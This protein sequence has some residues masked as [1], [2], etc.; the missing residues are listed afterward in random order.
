MARPQHPLPHT[1]ST[2]V[3]GLPGF[4]GGTALQLQQPEL[5]PQTHY[6]VLLFG[7]LLGLALV[8]R[9]LPAGW[10]RGLIAAACM[11]AAGFALTGVRASVF[12][13]AALQPHLEGRDLQ[14]TGVVA[15]M[16]QV[17]E[18]GSRF[19]LQVEQ[20]T[21]EGRAV[22]LPALIYLSWYSGAIGAAGNGEAAQL[23]YQP[24]E[25]RAGERWSMLVRLKAP[26][27]NLNPHGFDYELWLWEHG[28]QATGYVRAGSADPPPR[29]WAQTWRHPVEALRQD[30]RERILQRV[31][32]RSV[33]GVLAA[34]VVGDQNAIERADWDSFRAA[35]VAHLMSIS[36][37]HV[38]MFA[39]FAA[40]LVGAL[41][42]R[43]GV[44]C[45]WCSASHASIVGGLLLAT[46]YALFSGWGAPSQRTIWML[47]T[48]GLLRLSARRWPWPV[49]WLLA[50]VA[51][52]LLDPW[53]LNQPGFWLSFVAVAVLFAS[54]S[55]APTISGWSTRLRAMLREQW[56]VTAALTPLS[57][58]LFGQASV[59]GLAANLLAIPWVT[60]LVT[61]LALAGVV[62]APLWDLAAG[63]V[64]LLV[65]TLQLLLQLPLSSVSV[66]QAPLWAG[67]AGVA[68]GV[69]LVLRLPW[70]VRAAGLPLLLPVMLWQFERPPAGEFDVLAAD[71]GQGNA[72]LVRTTSHALLYDA[73]PRFSRES[74]AGHR[75]LVPLLRSLGVRLDRVVLSHRDSDHVGGAAAVLAMQ[76]GASVLSSIEAGHPLQLLRSATRCE[77]GQ[78]WQWDGVLFS[79]LHPDAADYQGAPRPNTLSCVL[80]ISSAEAPDRVARVALLTGDIERP[81]E[82][83]LLAAGAPLKANLLLVPH[84]GS[85]TSSSAEFLD[86]V[87][88]AHAMLQ[89][90][91]RNRF[92]HPAAEVRE[93]Y[94]QRQ[95]QLV[96]SPQCGASAWQSWKADQVQCQR[97]LG[98]RYWHHQTP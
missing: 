30:V 60:L 68:G 3:A 71:I 47:L 81:Q 54:G 11:A 9:Y 62:V 12:L 21:L 34:L 40:A 26:H 87:A 7:G 77:R 13:Q 42:R 97:Q 82:L 41:W 96:G 22:Q 63:A 38:T 6:P 53:A 35:G 4:V 65:S 74:D 93:R 45:L 72:V 86:V 14:I 37:L 1:I 88:P 24:P 20:A 18:A 8:L 73:G 85:K 46:A 57:L 52:V 76:P 67:V 58:L 84:H 80:R 64:V 89:S 31:P 48:V 94:L 19:R 5:W 69:L 75:V 59:V 55:A 91:Y 27:G 83:R 98:R 95:I 79:I 66:A 49:V 70:P 15:N 28:L 33:A 44:L 39:W 51:V 10:Q 56:V 43:S 2:L 92:G 36:G 29:R 78:Q 32:D 23:V 50:C 90:G 17:N 25:L 16:P 61:P